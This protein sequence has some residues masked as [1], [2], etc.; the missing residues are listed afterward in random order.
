MTIK[1]LRLQTFK[2]DAP[3]LDIPKEKLERYQI[4]NGSEEVKLLS[5]AEEIERSRG[6]KERGQLEKTL[7]DGRLVRKEGGRTLEVKLFDRLIAYY[8]VVKG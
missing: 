3:V 5:L 6:E 4:K 2:E 1:I 8:E 7:T